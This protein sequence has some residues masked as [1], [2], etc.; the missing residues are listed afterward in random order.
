MLTPP[1]SFSSLRLS[2]P[3]MQTPRL[4]RVT[5]YSS[6]AL[7]NVMEDLL[8]LQRS[9]GKAEI[10]LAAADRHRALQS[11]GDLLTACLRKHYSASAA[12]QCARLMG[13]CCNKCG[14]KCSGQAERGTI[15]WDA[16]DVMACLLPL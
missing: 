1:L 15:Y 11:G 12:E 6:T 13:P 5:G 4:Q 10:S 14:K 8:L 9:Y 16:Y 2:P 3:L 7:L